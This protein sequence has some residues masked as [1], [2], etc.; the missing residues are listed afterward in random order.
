MTRGFVIGH[1]N[2][3]LAVLFGEIPGQFSDDGNKAIACAL[4]VLINPDWKTVFEPDPVIES[5]RRITWRSLTIPPT[6]RRGDDEGIAR[7]EHGLVA[8]A[9]RFDRPGCAANMIA[10]DFART[11]TCKAERPDRAVTRQDG[12]LER[13]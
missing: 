10:A 1:A 9:Q 12:E 2:I 3:V 7:F 11:S 13:I 6:R 8:P 5:I 4:P